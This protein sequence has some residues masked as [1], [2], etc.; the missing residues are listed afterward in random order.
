MTNETTWQHL[1]EAQPRLA[2]LESEIRA[3]TPPKDLRALRTK[4]SRE[5]AANVKLWKRALS[6]LNPVGW[7]FTR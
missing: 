6:W 3:S 1:V 4:V 7:W 5:L 2:E